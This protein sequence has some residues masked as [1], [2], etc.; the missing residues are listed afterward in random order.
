MR[1]LGSTTTAPDTTIR[2][3]AGSSSEDPIGFNG[4][5]NFYAY[6]LND[7]TGFSDPMGL[8]P[9]LNVQKFVDFMNN[10]AD[11]VTKSKGDCAQ[12]VKRGLAAGF[13]VKSVPLSNGP[14]NYGP[15][16]EKL[17]SRPIDKHSSLMPGDVMIFQPMQGRKNGHIQMWNGTQW[18]SDYMQPNMKDGYPGPGSIYEKANPAYQLYRDSN[19]CGAG[20][21]VQSPSW[22]QRAWTYL[23]ELIK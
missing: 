22:L 8:A 11:G 23:K 7:P 3:S 19:V 14:H 15:G 2:P 12:S 5:D 20:N 1:M 10:Q 6:V 21:L 18:V 9:C 4:G 16:L 13:G 17:G